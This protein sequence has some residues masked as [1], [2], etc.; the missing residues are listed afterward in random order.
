MNLSFT[1]P[2]WLGIIICFLYITEKI[3]NILGRRNIKIL[4]YKLFIL[5]FYKNNEDY[6]KLKSKYK[7]A[8]KKAKAEQEIKMQQR[9]SI[10]KMF[11]E[12]SKKELNQNKDL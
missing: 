3:I 9:S 1:I 11:D 10:K 4:F 6:Y 12:A 5:L 7:Q 8:N 2:L